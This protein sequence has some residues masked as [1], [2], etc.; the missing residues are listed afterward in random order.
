M[1]TCAFCAIQWS[2]NTEAIVHKTKSKKHYDVLF[3]SCC[4]AQSINNRMLLLF[5]LV[6]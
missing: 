4:L 1:D 6:I 5:L 3:L 2:K